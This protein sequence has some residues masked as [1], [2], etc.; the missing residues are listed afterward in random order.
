MQQQLLSNFGKTGV[1][2]GLLTTPVDIED[3]SYF[4][5]YFVI[6][7]YNPVLTAGK[8]PFAFNG[9]SLLA[10]GSEIEIE[11]LDSEGNSL[12]MERP[13]SK[14]QFSDV[15]TFLIS[16]HVYEETYNG[17]GKLILRGITTKGE[18]VRWI[19]NITIDKTLKNAAKVRFYNKPQLE[20]RSLLYPVI[21]NEVAANASHQVVLNGS[22]YSYATD[23]KKDTNR[24]MVNPK[25]TDMDYRITL[26]VNDSV[27]A[28]AL[29]PTTSFNTQME[30]QTIT[31][32]ANTIAQPFTTLDKQTTIT[33]S[34]QIK[35]VVD[36][37]TAKLSD[38]F[39]YSIGKDEI[40]TNIN[41]GTFTSSYKWVSYN[42]QADAYLKYV[43]ATG[44]AIE[45]KKSYAEI[46]YR[47]LRTFSGF[48]A[49]HKLYRKSLLY[50]GDFQLI[51]DEPLGALEILND[52]VTANQAYTEMGIFYNQPHINKY[53]FTSSNALQ[54]SHSVKPFI[55]AMR[56][57]TSANFTDANGTAHVI[58]KT[59]S[60]NTTGSAAYIPYS[61]ASFEYQS[62]S[63]YNS[64]FI[65]LKSGALYVLSMNVI[66]EKETLDADAK[67]SFYFTS[68][69][70]SI[71]LEKDYI[72][73]L[74]WKL[75]EVSTRDETNLKIFS[76][77]QM[78]FF[79]PSADYFG[80]I[81]VAPYHCNATL[82][83][84]SLKVYGDYGFSPDIL[85]TKIP[86]QVNVANEIFQLK[87]ELFDI[88]STLVY[89]D[90]STIQ[91]FDQHGDSLFV[92]VGSSNLDPSQL[93]FVSGSLVISQSLLLPNI[94]VCAPSANT[95]ML[96]Y[97]YPSNYPPDPSLG[98][99]VVCHTNVSNLDNIGTEYINVDTDDGVL[100]PTSS[101]ALSVRYLS[102]A[103][104]GGPQGRRIYITT[105]GA[106]TTEP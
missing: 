2:L 35:K 18:T 99:G 69:I 41:Y 60:P 4:S 87:A 19:G 6:A 100:P 89:S 65:E 51:A 54:L 12:Y 33:Q 78:L 83:E 79:T 68:S 76:E 1:S 3:T 28:P 5:K 23:P 9:S 46:I 24:T 70:P 66:I 74:G 91:N 27:V 7:E 36:S 86:F 96:S 21:S 49:R 94:G 16:I 81:F 29:Y 90:L 63:S 32:V 61:S 62:G 103:E 45:V 104:V 40:I 17:P 25:K 106:K 95:R 85:F 77:K 47:N 98:D 92:Y 67:I 30:G 53:W 48:I 73:P 11:C 105:A 42:T 71:Q 80:T 52:P 50:P 75:G 64:N 93:S 38:A 88:N 26:N 13:K 58:V 37:K 59:D 55:N 102:S 57:A 39:Y 10:K 8:N 20:A 44:P 97:V 84:M 72:T 31:I 14:S 101:R 15:A 56:I 34:F 22:F 43:P 82:S